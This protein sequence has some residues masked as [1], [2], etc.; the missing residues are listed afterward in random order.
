MPHE[1]CC[2]IKD[3]VIVFFYVDDIIVAYDRHSEDHYKS[4][5]KALREQY[6]M[7]GGDDL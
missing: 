4:I 7:T 2:I 3:G 6:T 5:I 1:P